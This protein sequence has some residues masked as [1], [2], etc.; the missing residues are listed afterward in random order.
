MKNLCIQAVVALL[1]T[2]TCSGPAIAQATEQ[3]PVPASTQV[4]AEVPAQVST[5]APAEVATEVEKEAGK[6]AVK[7]PAVVFAN[8]PVSTQGI[9]QLVLGLVVVVAVIL[10]LARVVRRM[11]GVGGYAMGS[12]KVLGG[13]SMGARERVVLMQVGDTQLLLGVA[14]GRI[15]TLHV[16]EQPVQ[17]ETEGDRSRP[18][19][20]FAERL[21]TALK[22]SAE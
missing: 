21:K 7:T 1:L 14:P 9:L 15:Q 13:L 3:V 19:I 8:D 11:G 16:L 6:S 20:G 4:S 5:Q 17:M 18:G 22:G 2:F 12:M 10:L